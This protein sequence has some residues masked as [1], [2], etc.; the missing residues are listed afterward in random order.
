MASCQMRLLVCGDEDDIS[1][2]KNISMN[3]VGNVATHR[4]E[5]ISIPMNCSG[6]RT[7]LSYRW[8]KTH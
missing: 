5:N 4:G 6:I 2:L 3:A 7:E 1:S 8:K